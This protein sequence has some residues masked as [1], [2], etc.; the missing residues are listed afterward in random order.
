MRF[1]FENSDSVTSEVNRSIGATIPVDYRY[2]Y[3]YV[4]LGS[5]DFR[6]LNLYGIV[7][8]APLSR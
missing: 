4:I 8:F 7:S 1:V 6:I 2:S 3:R 5:F